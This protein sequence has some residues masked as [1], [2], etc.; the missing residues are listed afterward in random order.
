MDEVFETGY[1]IPFLQSLEQFLSIKMVYEAVMLSFR[2][3][4]KKNSKLFLIPMSGMENILNAIHYSSGI[5]D[6][7][8][9]SKCTWMK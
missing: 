5:M 6:T 3:S 9:A 1:Y 4:Y 2:Q 7:F 8:F